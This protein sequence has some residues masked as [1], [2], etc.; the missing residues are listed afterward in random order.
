[1]RRGCIVCGTVEDVFFATWRGVG[2]PARERTRPTDFSISPTFSASASR[3]RHQAAPSVHRS[4]P[5]SSQD[6]DDDDERHVCVLASLASRPSSPFYFSRGQLFA[7]ATFSRP[8]RVPPSPSPLAAPSK[9][10]LPAAQRALLE[11]R[12]QG[13][14]V[15]ELTGL[16]EVGK[17]DVPRG[18]SFVAH[19]ATFLS[20]ARPPSLSPHR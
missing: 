9:L 18:Q 1:V 13:F 11:A 15:S 19:R 10:P 6:V 3:L 12:M 20:C 8:P 16:D 14:D 4:L 5:P 2:L 7:R 17:N